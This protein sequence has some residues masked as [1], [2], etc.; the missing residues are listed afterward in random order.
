MLCVEVVS[1]GRSSQ[2]IFSFN[3]FLFKSPKFTWGFL[4]TSTL[5]I[6][7]DKQAQYKCPLI[8]LF[9]Y[10]ILMTKKKNIFQ[11]I[12]TFFDKEEDSVRGYLSKR[13]IVYA[14]V[15]G[16]AVVLFW[17][18]V[19]M[20][21][22]MFSFLTGPVSIIISTI[23]MLISGVFVSYFVGDMIIISGL[24]KDKKVMDKTAEEIVKE[25][26]VIDRI[27]EKID[28][29]EEKIEEFIKDHK[30]KLDFPNKPML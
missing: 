1:K 4:Y 12:I 8:H 26:E 15:A 30:D 13:P 25:E 18:G 5:Q 3:R 6:L 23:I 19:W 21:A 24:T 14:L 17:R 16:I 11:H 22:D 29:L 20:T 2:L 28:N 10:N 9:C 27:E 7:Q